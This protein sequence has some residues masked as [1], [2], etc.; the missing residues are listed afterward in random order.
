MKCVI[1]Q[2]SYI[3][4]RGY[5]HQIREADI[6]VFYDDVQF[7]KH[8]WRNRNRIPTRSGPLWLTVPVLAS[9]APATGL[10]IHEVQINWDRAWNRKQWRTIEQNY[11]K[12]P[13]FARYAPELERFFEGRPELLVD[14]TIPLTEWAAAELGVS[15]TRYL[16][17]SQ[18]GIPGHRTERL[19]AILDHLEADSYLSGPSARDYL[20]EAAFVDAGIELTYMD[21][22]YPPYEQLHQPFE[23]QVSIIDLLFLKGPE[24]PRWIWGVES[25]AQADR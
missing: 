12:A 3:P 19:L 18:L 17:S 21:Y 24:A 23:P 7:D 10:P 20:D 4:W 6:F 11:S 14:L 13:F 25:G 2:P 1:L 16:R 8:G 22:D 5:F 9:D 15:D